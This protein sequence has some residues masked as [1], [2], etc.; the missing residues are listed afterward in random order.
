MIKYSRNKVNSKILKCFPNVKL[1]TITNNLDSYKS[2]KP[3]RVHLAILKLCNNDIE[4]L[5]ELVTTANNDFRDVIAWA[6][7]PEES[8]NPFSYN[9]EELEEIR[10]RDLQQYLQWLGSK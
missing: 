10:E 4:K 3:E 7:Y 8:K 2:T 1:E 5:K 9:N 6:E